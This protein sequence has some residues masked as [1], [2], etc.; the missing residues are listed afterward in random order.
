MNQLS[1]APLL[2]LESISLERGGKLLCREL[3]LTIEAR[4][5]WALLGCNGAGKTTLLHALLGLL[6]LCGG[7]IRVLNEPL[8]ASTRRQLARN[9]GLLFQEG[10]DSLP[11]T[12]LETV[13]L[14]RYPHAQSLLTDSKADKQIAFEALAELDL[15]DFAE[16]RIDTLSGGERQRLALATLFA[17]E[18]RLYLLDEPSNHLD[19]AFQVRLLTIL[20]RKLAR[21]QASM[22][23]ATHDIN[24]A[25]RFCEHIVL[26]LPE[27]RHLAGTR[28][29]ILT[30]ENLSA[31]YG[32]RVRRMEAEGVL[33]F[34][35]SEPD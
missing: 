10:L 14:G 9:L 5:S 8:A 32:C 7:E 1:P 17:Q 21:N 27:G 30:E 3:S 35:P 25:A 29:D 20:Q 22:M 19:V 15:E 2:H 31:A 11:A 13:M 16:R 12:V 33:F 18:P 28:E 26:L 6:P 4:Q 23:M 34:Y 24:L